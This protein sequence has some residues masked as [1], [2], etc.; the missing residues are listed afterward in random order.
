MLSEAKP[1]QLQ[2]AGFSGLPFAEPIQ[3]VSEFSKFSLREENSSKDSQML[4]IRQNY[5][6]LIT[7]KLLL[8]SHTESLISLL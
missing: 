4:K 7:K 3:Q 5:S 2:F 6:V 8:P 1:I